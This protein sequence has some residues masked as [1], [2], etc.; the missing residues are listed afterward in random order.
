M[1]KLPKIDLPVFETEVRGRTI[2]YRPFTVKEEKILLIA[3]ESK[4]NMKSAIEAIKQVVNNCLIDC[5]VKDLAS[6]ELQYVLLLIRAKSVN[7]KIRFKIK[8]PDTQEDITLDMDLNNVVL[9]EDEEHTN[10][11]KVDDTY[12]LFMKYPTIEQYIQI[13]DNSENRDPFIE[14]KIM[15]S[16]FDELVSEQETHVFKDFSQKEIE[17]FADNLQGETIE[18]IKKFMETMPKLRQEFKYT[19]SEGKEKTFV[20][21]GI[22]SFFI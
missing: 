9:T 2:K 6:F 18:E 4:D 8:D 11:I 12:T 14:F 17:E 7:N 19:N 3:Q 22:R 15:L 21:E 1:K 13:F 16:C 10:Q 20:L 5:S